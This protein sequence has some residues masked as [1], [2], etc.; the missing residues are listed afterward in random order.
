MRLVSF[1]PLASTLITRF[2]KK[3]M[4]SSLTFPENDFGEIMGFPLF[5]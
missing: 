2:S 1:Q 4:E 5:D 3:D